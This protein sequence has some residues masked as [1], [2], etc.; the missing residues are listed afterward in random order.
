MTLAALAACAARIEALE[1]E[2]AHLR[3]ICLVLV[4]GGMHTPSTGCVVCGAPHV[5]RGFCQRHYD[6][7]RKVVLYH[8]K[9]GLT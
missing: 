1:A 4:R 7:Y 8:R 3:R 5:A 6:R 9:R 2:N